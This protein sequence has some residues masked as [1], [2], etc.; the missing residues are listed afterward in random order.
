[1]KIAIKSDSNESR[2]PT[3]PVNIESQLNNNESI[4]DIN[5][6][7]LIKDRDGN[8]IEILQSS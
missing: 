5:T 7:R 8:P 6:S 2:K 4:R 3:S 1:M